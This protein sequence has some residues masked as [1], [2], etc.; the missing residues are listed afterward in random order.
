[1]RNIKLTVSYDGTDFAGFQSQLDVRTVEDTLKEALGKITGKKDKIYCAGRTDS[2]VHA[3]MQVINFFSEKKNMT[4]FNWIM[5]LNT[6]LPTDVRI[7]GCC[8]VSDDF[9]ARKSAVKRE[10][11][12][13]M[14]N[15]PFISA[16]DIRFASHHPKPLDITLLQQYADQ[17]TGT[18]DYTSFCSTRDVCESKIRRIETFNIEKK[19]NLI[20]F[21]ITGTAFFQYMVRTIIGT[22]LQLHKEKKDPSEIKKILQKKNRS[23][24]G[25]TYYPGGLIF[26]KVYY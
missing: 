26:K 5:A 11:W 4:E 23:F 12:Y 6:L 10:Y 16:L 22:M 8:F 25:P 24:A 19:D 13:R 1:M 14:I 18:H 20:V 17:F 3:E 9:N 15:S 2:G 7:T 21:K